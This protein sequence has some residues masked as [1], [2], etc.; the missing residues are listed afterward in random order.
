MTNPE[1]ALELML[2]ALVDDCAP[3]VEDDWPFDYE[4][5]LCMWCETQRGHAEG[6]AWETARA[7]LYGD[8]AR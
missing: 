4:Q 3:F 1:L 7:Y 2:Q 6:C 5:G 8:D